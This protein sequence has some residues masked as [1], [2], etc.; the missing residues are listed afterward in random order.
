MQLALS[1]QSERLVC[2]LVSIAN[3]CGSAFLSES[4]KCQK[5]L[6]KIVEQVNELH[7][8]NTRIA[9]YLRWC[10]DQYDIKIVKMEFCA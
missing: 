4:E 1:E 7:I 3:I 5:E 6:T 10:G 8:N 9:N 2:K